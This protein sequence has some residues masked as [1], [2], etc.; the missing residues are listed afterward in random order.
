MKRLLTAAIA[1]LMLTGCGDTSKVDRLIAA[2][3]SAAEQISEASDESSDSR[4]NAEEIAADYWADRETTP[5]PETTLID[6]AMLANGDI[7]IDLTILNPNMLYAQVFEMTGDP[8]AYQG[9]TVRAKGTFLSYTDSETGENVFAVFMTDAAACC[10][11]GL[12]F[13]RSGEFSYPDI[14]DPITVTGTFSSYKIG[15]FTYCE[16]I[17]AVLEVG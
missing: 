2:E 13:K 4:T 12:E 9:K 8:E 7:D 14:D 5:V 11:Q 16:L 1:L 10:A 15:V 6:E 3:S 17:D